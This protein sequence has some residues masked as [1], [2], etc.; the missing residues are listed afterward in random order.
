MPTALSHAAVPLAFRLGFGRDAIS[1]RLLAAGVAASMAPDADVIAF[2]LGIP[3]A[4]D[5][6]HRGFTHSLAFAACVGLAGGLSHRA[7][8]SRFLAAFAFL[9]AATASHPILDALTDGGLGVALFWPLSSERLFM[10]LRPIHV[11]PLSLKGL[12]SARGAAVIASELRWV[13]LPCSALGA[14]LAVRRWRSES[15]HGGSVAVCL[16]S[17]RTTPSRPR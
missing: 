9:F 5:L 2:R 16:R 10:P 14:L 4:A 6:G 3:Y 17:H 8:R 1:G 12:F 7:L 15:A 11:A 13:W